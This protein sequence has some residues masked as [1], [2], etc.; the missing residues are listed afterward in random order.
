MI[1][2]FLPTQSACGLG[3]HT[4]SPDEW[5]DEVDLLGLVCLVTTEL[6]LV[7]YHVSLLE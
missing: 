2:H 4:F 1:E 5:M 7:V 3:F 6:V